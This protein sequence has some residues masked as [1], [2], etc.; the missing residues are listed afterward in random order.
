MTLDLGWQGMQS[1][2][3]VG[4]LTSLGPTMFAF[5]QDGAT[6]PSNTA[7]DSV[8]TAEAAAVTMPNVTEANQ[9]EVSSDDSDGSSP[10]G[11]AMGV[12]ELP[13]AATTY[14]DYTPTER[15]SEDR[16]ISFPVDI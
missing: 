12:E 14:D 13:D 10:E 5:A 7:G 16:S 6:R 4:L 9:N 1:K 15:I 8:Q 2:L 3:L 11:S